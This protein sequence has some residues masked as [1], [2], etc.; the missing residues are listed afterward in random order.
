MRFRKV[1]PCEQAVQWSSLELDGELSEFEHAALHRHLERCP[2][3]RTSAAQIGAFTKILRESPLEEIQAPVAAAQPW[4]RRRFGRPAAVVAL[5]AA[6]AFAASLSL[7]STTGSGLTTSTFGSAAQPQQEL[8]VGQE[9]VRT[10][11]VVFLVPT[12]PPG[13]FG[14]RPLL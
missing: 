11:P 12:P 5:G 2:A 9:H 4:Q 14:A 10:E 6:A 1:T 3:C 8:A 13:S 7:V